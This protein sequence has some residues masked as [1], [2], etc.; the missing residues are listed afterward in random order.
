GP[1]AGVV[2]T[3][4][5]VHDAIEASRIDIARAGAQVEVDVA[6][7]TPAILGDAPALRSA[8]QN[9]VGNAVK[10]GGAR[11]WVRVS[12]RAGRVGRAPGVLVTVEDRGLGI[13]SEDRAHVFEPFYRGR[14]AVA[15]QIQGS[16]L[17]LSL[18]SRIAAAHG[19]RVTLESEPGRGSRFTLHL[20]AAP[21]DAVAEPAAG[22]HPATLR[23]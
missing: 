16:G 17:G 23:S 20:P 3:A 4:G 15:R 10:Y 13:A 6:P 18:V 7:D 5:L 14:E 22:T 9:L 11:P 8:V 19:G 12:A 2:G 21:D 1:A